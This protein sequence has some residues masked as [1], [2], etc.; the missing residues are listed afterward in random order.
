MIAQYR[1][2]RATSTFET[3]FSMITAGNGRLTESNRYNEVADRDK[4]PPEPGNL[5]F[6]LTLGGTVMTYAILWLKCRML[7]VSSISKTGL[8]MIGVGKGLL[9]EPTKYNEVADRG[10]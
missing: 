7:C 6:I 2:L 5:K 4:W 1:M 3:N 8:S 10:Q 9:T